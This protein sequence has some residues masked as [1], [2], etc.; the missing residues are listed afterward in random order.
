MEAVLAPPAEGPRPSTT[1]LR[2]RRSWWADRLDRPAATWQCLL[3]Y[4]VATALFAGIVAAAGGPGPV[5]A[6]ESVYSTW[7]IE[8]GQ[9][10]CAFPSVTEPHEPLVAPLYPLVSGAVAALTHIGSTSSVPF[11]SRTEL[12]T[13]CQHADAAI[14]AWAARAGPTEPTLWIALAAWL[15]LLAGVAAFLRATRRG[16]Q[17]WEPATVLALAC[18]PP[19]WISVRYYFH[20][21]DLAA[22]GLC[23]AALACAARGRWAAS[24]AFVAC[25]VL[26]QQFALLVAVPLL[27]LA[28]V[29]RGRIRYVAGGVVATVLLVAP[30]VAAS[31]G[32]VWR[33]ITIGS[34]DNAS[35][36]GTVVWEIDHN[37]ALVVV[38]VS[39]VLPIVVALAI[40]LWVSRRL[41]PD[42]ATNR[43]T[44]LVALVAVTLA[45][46]LV[47]EQNIFSYYFMA[48]AVMLVL[49]DVTRGRIRGSLVV[50]LVAVCFVFHIP[51]YVFGAAGRLHPAVLFPPLLMRRRRRCRPRRRGRPPWPQPPRT[52]TV[53]A[54]PLVGR[55]P[56][57]AGH[58]AHGSQPSLPLDP[59]AWLRQVVV[60]GTGILLAAGPL[61]EEVHRSHAHHE[62]PLA[63]P[64]PP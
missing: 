8:H 44:A 24:G 5:D 34:G 16:R 4:V 23:L 60:A 46:R 30:L 62:A 49:L 3:A 27:V 38:G 21:Q 52:D 26:S 20:P 41:G 58:V 40:S 55:R 6:P 42:V 25:A 29:G 35:T 31:S 37:H 53:V 43:P 48:L 1:S 32:A 15:V 17:R 18:L 64:T 57:R 10:T 61:L 19:V 47:F 56:V 45:L 7:A 28:P 59:R 13:T 14:A 9:L 22:V 54:L 39:R 2:L 50:W 11:P 51:N 33:A 63:H 12:G 36:G